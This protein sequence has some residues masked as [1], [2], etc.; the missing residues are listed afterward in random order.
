MSVIYHL[1]SRSHWE[2]IRSASEYRA[3]SLEKEGFIHCSRDQEQ[4][5]RV[6]ARLY[7]GRTDMLALTLDVDRLTS[8][9]KWEPSRSGEVYPHIYGPLNTSAVVELQAVVIGDNGGISLV[10]G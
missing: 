8:P 2:A 10:R 6:A 7:P 4:L 3:D 5:L 9:V 1:I